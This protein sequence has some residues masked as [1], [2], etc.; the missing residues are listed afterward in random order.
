MATWAV[1]NHGTRTGTHRCTSY[2]STHGHRT[3]VSKDFDNSCKLAV[4]ILSMYQLLQYKDIAVL[5][6]GRWT[7]CSVW[8]EPRSHYGPVTHFS[9]CPLSTKVGYSLL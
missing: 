5:M 2:Y 9:G 1:A 3:D 4:C 6:L 7:G 8:S